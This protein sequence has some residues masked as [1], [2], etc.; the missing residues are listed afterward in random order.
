MVLCRFI[1]HYK[2]KRI[3]PKTFNK[4]CRYPK[5]TKLYKQGMRMLDIGQITQLE[6]NFN[7]E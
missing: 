1:F 4:F 2:D 6:I 3:G 7:H 5:K